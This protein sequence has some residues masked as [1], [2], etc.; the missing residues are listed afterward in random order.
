MHLPVHIGYSMIDHLMRIVALKP[1]VRLQRIAV[2]CRSSFNMLTNLGLNC[3][4]LAVR[5]H[6]GTYLAALSVLATF[7]NSHDRSFVFSARAGDAART[8]RNVHVARFATDKGFVR[9]DVTGELL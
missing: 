1:L 8:L 4:L 9:F 5:N 2:E 3:V 7:Q 6:G